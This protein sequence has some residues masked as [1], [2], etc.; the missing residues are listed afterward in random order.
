MT[1][2]GVQLVT[3][4]VNVHV[5][6]CMAV[7]L[8]LLLMQWSRSSGVES[9]KTAA[10]ELNASPAVL[11]HYSEAGYGLVR[12]TLG[13]VYSLPTRDEHSLFRLMTY[14]PWRVTGRSSQSPS[15][16]ESIVYNIRISRRWPS[17]FGTHRHPA[18]RLAGRPGHGICPPRGQLWSIASGQQ[19]V[20]VL[21][22]VRGSGPTAVTAWKA[23]HP[24]QD[25]RGR[26]G[27]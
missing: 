11:G 15:D 12:L 17:G 25:R 18:G 8:H 6:G 23:Q 7:W 10:G 22:A 1:R 4:T 5:Y 13:N 9:I 16:V 20:I 14:T 24:N 27:E 19:Q 21:M 3:P 26:S 2:G